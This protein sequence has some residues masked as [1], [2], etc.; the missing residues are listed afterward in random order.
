[1][2]NKIIIFLL[3]LLSVLLM[4]SCGSK[5][6]DAS[7]ANSNHFSEQTDHKKEGNTLKKIEGKDMFK[8]EDGILIK[9]LGNYKN[10]AEVVLPKEVK[11]I[12]KHAF[13]ISKKEKKKEK[14]TLHLTIGQNV[15][16]EEC[17]F[18]KCGPM[19]IEFEEGREKIE[20]RSFM[21]GPD[22][23]SEVEVII[24][25]SVKVIEERAFYNDIGYS[26]VIH[27]KMEEGLERIEDEAF[28]GIKIDKIPDSVLYIGKNAFGEIENVKNI[29][30]SNLETLQECSFQC[31]GGKVVIPASVKYIAINAI[32]WLDCYNDIHG[33]NVTKDNPYYKSDENGWLYSKDGKTLYFAY[34]VNTGS[35]VIPKGVKYVYKEGID[36][37]NEDTPEGEDVKILADK[38]VE[39]R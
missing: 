30:P 38:D 9:Y 12:G 5:E 6:Q 26:G 20:K 29:L 16:L 13:A 8:I 7:N 34:R 14:K 21:W 10:E 36:L 24:P 33:Y 22:S 3:L 39:F 1:M 4:C 23:D 18:E 15:K 31:Y 17:S 2:K 25:K 37:G 32:E 35:L 11:K 27:V 28:K 19:K